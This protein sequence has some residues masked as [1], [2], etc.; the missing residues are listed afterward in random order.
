MDYMNWI[1]RSTSAPRAVA[2]I[3]IGV[4]AFVFIASYTAAAIEPTELEPAKGADAGRYELEIKATLA[5]DMRP[6]SKRN[7]LTG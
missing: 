7:F 5:K 6:N 2:S 4:L 3:S 1:L